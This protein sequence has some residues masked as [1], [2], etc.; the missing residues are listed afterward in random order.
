[1]KAATVKDLRARASTILA[2][3]R[4][5]GEV[6]ITM[7]GKSIAVIKPMSGIEKPF[8]P[9]GFGMWKDRREMTDV[10]KTISGIAKM[11]ER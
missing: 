1:M 6:V 3:V 8:S 4:K 5:G 11:V 2:H 10:K 7:R 9:V